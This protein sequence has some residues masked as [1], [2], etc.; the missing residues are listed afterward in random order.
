M[1]KVLLKRSGTGVSA[2]ALGTWAIGGKQWGETDDNTSIAAIKAAVGAGM[3]F[4]DTAPIYG[5][6]HS[7][8]LVGK[9]VKGM[10]ERVFIATKC[11]LIGQGG[12]FPKKD[13]SAASINAEVEESLR[14]LGTDYIDLYQTH[15]PDKNTALEETYGA[16]LKLKEQGKI[17]HIG[18]CNV[19][20]ELLRDIDKICPLDTVQNEYSFFKQNM[21]DDVFDYCE[22]NGIGFLGYG[23][24]AGGI[25]SGKYDKAPNLPNSDPRNFFYRL[26]RG[27]AFENAKAAVARFKEIGQKYNKPTAAVAINWARAQRPFIIPLVGAKTAAQAAENAQ[28]ATFEL[29]KTD[30]DFLNGN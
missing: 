6:G 9:A 23:P 8:G 15:W 10:R 19:G 24:L 11:G 13:L 12:G 17:K 7:E 28:A 14:R 21:G 25:L 26:Y 22:K 2:L 3:T 16:L 30:V 5:F 4:V 27:E 20:I 1:Q 18:A 29:T